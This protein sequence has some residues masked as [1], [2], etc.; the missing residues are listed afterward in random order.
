MSI[1]LTFRLFQTKT[2]QPMQWAFS[3]G[4]FPTSKQREYDGYD[5]SL[6][7][8]IVLRPVPYSTPST[9]QT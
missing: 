9:R 8:A 6:A 4:K 7:I 3:L 5:L 1:Y 2:S